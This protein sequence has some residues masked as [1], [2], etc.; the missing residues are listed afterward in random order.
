MD[1]DELIKKDFFTKELV[2]S[3]IPSPKTRSEFYRRYS[4]RLCERYDM[5]VLG[6][7]LSEDYQSA[8]KG[9]DVLINDSNDLIFMY[10]GNLQYIIREFES[11]EYK[12]RVLSK[13]RRDIKV[14]ARFKSLN[15][16][17]A[18]VMSRMVDKGMYIKGL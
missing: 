4:N 15:A 11:V 7:I 3:Y 16:S 9:L 2:R 8:I 17:C 10:K 1:I 18:Y 13:D 14:N 6:N 12:F 5:A